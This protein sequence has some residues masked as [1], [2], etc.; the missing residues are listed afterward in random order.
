MLYLRQMGAKLL[1]ILI[2]GIFVFSFIWI[3]VSILKIVSSEA[4]DFRVLWTFANHLR[5]GENLYLN[6]DI[7][8]PNPYPPFTSL[9]YYPLTFLPY[10]KA[11]A[12]FIFLIFASLVATVIVS[13]RLVTGKIPIW[14]FLSSCSL[15]F[16]SF[17]AKFTLGMGQQ[18]SVAFLLLLFSYLFY[19]NK[20]PVLSGILLGLSV[21]FK[22]V[23]GFVVLF[24]V[25]EKAWMVIS[26]AF[27]T[28][29]AEAAFIFSIT[30]LNLFGDW[31]KQTLLYLPLTGREVYY[32]QG[33]VGFISRITQKPLLIKNSLIFFSLSV[34]SGIIFAV[35]KAK[36]KNLVFSLFIIS[37]LLLDT[38]SWQHHFVWLIFPFVTLAYHIGKSK[39]AVLSALIVAAYLLVGWNF[40]TP[41]DYPAILLSNQFYG[42]IILWGLNFYLL[43]KEKSTS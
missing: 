22:P 1:K 33:F 30:K 27:V 28:F 24:F 19:R 2:A 23:L 43:L 11:Q 38:L 6:Q 29:I 18:N 21:S 16:L 14:M 40:K 32:N 7:S 10:T 37:V 15:V 39:N 35:R 4:P 36:D 42:A 20:S 9:F 34:M 41:M 13:L 12:S 17:P 3:S 5:A 31:I 25:I 26:W 8:I